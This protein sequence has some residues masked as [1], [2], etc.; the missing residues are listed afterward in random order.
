MR[1]IK[2]FINSMENIIKPKKGLNSIN[3]KELWHYR[4]LFYFLAWRD[5]KVRYKQTVFGVGW[6]ILQ[7]FTM[8]VVFSIV[9]GAMAKVPSDNIPY[10]IFV[11]TGLLLWSLFSSALGG[12][13]QSLIGNAAIIQKVYVPKLIIAVSCMIV[14][15]VDFLFA[16][17]VLAGIMVYYG[18]L[19]DFK[20]L[21]LL[22]IVLIVVVLSSLGLGLFLA[23]LNV[24]YRD[25]RY[26]LPF[27]I[28]LL[29]FVTPVIYPISIVPEKFRW[30]LSLNP[31]TGA[32]ETFKAG[33]LNTGAINWNGFIISLAIAIAVFFLGLWYF[34]KT[35]KVFADII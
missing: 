7:P 23:A 17:L 6:A 34:L 5:I 25:V 24:R 19:P 18:F 10:P 11:Y 8:M 20:G 33:F 13:S 14:Y 22:P 21:I 9:F 15:L 2:N 26:V 27:F 16:S 31:M 4:E 3:F 28:Q 29:I 1:G 32:I 30:L 12:V 35:E